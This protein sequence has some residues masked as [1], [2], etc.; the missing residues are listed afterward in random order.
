M[1]ASR[2]RGNVIRRLAREFMVAVEKVS[3]AIPVALDSK[4]IG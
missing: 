1:G 2:G 4:A 3:V